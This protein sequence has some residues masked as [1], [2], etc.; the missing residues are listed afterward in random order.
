M[1]GLVR[2]CLRNYVIM[3]NMHL[4]QL[5]ELGVIKDERT[6]FS[7]KRSQFA[8]TGTK[9]MWYLKCLP[10]FHET[11]FGLPWQLQLFCSI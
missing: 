10:Q 9:Q 5:M 7:E 6:G 8:L 3:N 4:S 2:V 1:R 11:C